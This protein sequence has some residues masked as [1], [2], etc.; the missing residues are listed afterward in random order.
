M[1]SGKMHFFIKRLDTCHI[2]LCIIRK[3]NFMT[4]A[5][6]FCSPVE[7]SHIYRTSYLT[8]NCVEAG[9]PTFY[10]LAC[11][12]WCKCKVYNRSP[13]H[14]IDYAES[15]VAS[16]FA[17]NRNA[18]KLAQ[19]PSERSPEKFSLDHAVRLSTNRCII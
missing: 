6:A 17:V 4:T 2:S 11:S 19:K 15:Y 7:I 10:R 13:L 3:F 8:R 16:S 12:L 1:F 18:S 14:L 5:D 9:L